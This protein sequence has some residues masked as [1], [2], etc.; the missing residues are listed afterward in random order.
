M[1]NVISPSLTTHHVQTPYFGGSFTKN[2]RETHH[3]NSDAH[4]W[5]SLRESFAIT[6]TVCAIIIIACVTN[7]QPPSQGVSYGNLVAYYVAAGMTIFSFVFMDA[8]QRELL[9]ENLDIKTDHERGLMGGHIGTDSPHHSTT[10]HSIICHTHTITALHHHHHT[11][12]ISSSPSPSWP[13]TNHLRCIERDLD[14][15]QHHHVG[16]HQRW[17]WQAYCVHIRFWSDGCW[18][19]HLSVRKLVWNAGMM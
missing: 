3:C 12:I 4:M 13:T 15:V 17:C 11:I 2:C 7:D 10:A 16:H 5:S 19:H 14:C 1:I 9:Q 8:A 18:S 6:I